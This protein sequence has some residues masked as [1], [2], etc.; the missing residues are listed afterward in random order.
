MA[1]PVNIDKQPTVP[2]EQLRYRNHLEWKSSWVEPLILGLTLPEER[3][4][5][6]K[7]DHSQRQHFQI[8]WIE[9]DKL[10]H[11]KNSSHRACWRWSYGWNHCHQLWS[12]TGHHDKQK[13]CLEFDKL[14]C[15]CGWVRCILADD[16]AYLGYHLERILSWGLFGLKNFWKKT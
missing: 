4:R 13:N 1:L 12:L 8:E 16:C 15:G 3:S 2:N 7:H 11:N 6:G 5:P 14:Y 9:H 10:L